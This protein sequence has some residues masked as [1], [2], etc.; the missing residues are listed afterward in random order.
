M[1]TDHST[2]PTDEIAE[3]FDAI[4]PAFDNDTMYTIEKHCQEAG[5]KHGINRLILLAILTRTGEQLFEGA[6]AAGEALIEAYECATGTVAHYR[7]MGKMLEAAHM[8]MMMALCAIDTDAPDAPFT[9]ERF[10]AAIAAARA[11]RDGD[12]EDEGAQS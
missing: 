11:A 8:R 10:S 7:D 2:D 4:E 1:A 3:Q 6:L 12:D 9:Q 5:K